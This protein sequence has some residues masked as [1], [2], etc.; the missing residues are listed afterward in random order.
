MKLSPE[1]IAF[2]NEKGYLK[3]ENYLNPEEIDLLNSEL[4]NTIE[5]GSP[6]VILEKSGNVRSV[7]A[8]HFTNEIY[9]R[10]GKLDKFVRTAELLIGNQVYIHQYKINCKKG[11][12]SEWWEW[13]QDFPYWHID[14]GIEEP[15]LLN[16][17]IY[18]QDTDSLNGALLLIPTS[19]NNGIAKFAEKDN[20]SVAKSVNEIAPANKYQDNLSSLNSN[21]K[22]TVDHGVIRELATSN[23]IVT[24]DGKKGTVLFFHPNIFHASNNNM[25]PFDRNMILITYN[26]INNPPRNVV[27]ARPDFL[28][29]TDQEPIVNTADSLF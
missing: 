10:L 14:D 7:F 2:Y 28:S 5:K 23:A 8:P 3:L 12:Q 6:R 29:G 4:P 26:S 16:V 9:R 17:M 13:H 25:S 21:I 22:F 11:L 20:E 19:H 15:D 1:Q 27:N 18:L 24:A